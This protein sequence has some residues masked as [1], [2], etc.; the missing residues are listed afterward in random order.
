MEDVQIQNRSTVLQI[1]RS[2]KRI[3]RR[4]IA[5]LSG[6]TPSTITYII[7][8]LLEKGL[9]VET[10]QFAGQKG[11]RAIA[12]EINPD[13]CFVVGVRLARNYT[14]CG[15]FNLEARLL[16][17]ERVEIESLGNVDN[18]M[19]AMKD[20][21]RS[22]LEKGGVADKVIAIGIAAPGPL[23]VREGKITFVSNFPGWRNIPIREII[24][25]EFNIKTVIQHD[26]HAAA[27]AEKWFGVGQEAD[28]LVYVAAGRGV[29]AGIIINGRIYY[30]SSGMAGEIGHTTVDYHGPQCECG[31]QGCLELY[32]SSTALVRKAQSVVRDGGQETVLSRA[33]PLTLR[34]MFEAVKQGDEVAVNLVK[35]AA[36]YMGYGVVNLINNFNPDMVILGDEMSE[37]GEIWVNTV[38]EV[39]LP[40]LLPEVASQVRIEGASLKGD[41][42]LVGTG[43]IAIEHLFQNP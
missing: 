22:T 16:Y 30:G 5:S 41:P 40:R 35:E 20:M 27:L 29:G 28:N 18:V 26:A 37:A 8:D 42:F 2:R 14:V 21:I 32:C 7:R 39:A 12:L 36:T 24:Q 10:G 23:S 6:L 15:L 11:R 4:E 19:T 1:L 3:S 38:K 31:N 43:T 33:S 34:A 9:V 17:S 25:N 13:S